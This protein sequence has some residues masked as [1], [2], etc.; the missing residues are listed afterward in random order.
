MDVS[1]ATTLIG[2]LGFP[3]VA[4]IY[5]FYLIKDMNE[6]HKDE[7]AQLKESI[8]ANTS[9]IEKLEQLIQTLSTYITK[10]GSQ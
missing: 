4:C 8:S 7:V 3:I 9:A 2:S 10:G 1:T 6:K 5:M